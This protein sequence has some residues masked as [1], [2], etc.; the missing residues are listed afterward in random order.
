M[1]DNLRANL[2]QQSILAQG[3]TRIRR[4]LDLDTIFQ[5]TTAELLSVLGCD[6]AI[7]YQ[8]NPDWGGTIVAESVKPEWEPLRTRQVVEAELQRNTTEHENCILAWYKAGEPDADEPIEV[9]DTYLQENQGGIY[10]AGLPHRAVNDVTQAGFSDCYL[11]FLA[12]MQAKAYINTPLFLDGQLWGLVCV[13]QNAQPRVWQSEEINIVIQIGEHMTVALQQ[14]HLLKQTQQQA[15]NLLQAKETAEAANQAKSEFLSSMSHELR[16]PLNAIL[17]FAQLLTTATNLSPTQH[18]QLRIINRSG[19]HLLTL[20]NDVLEMSK[21]EAGQLAL[22]TTDCHLHGLL[23]DLEELLRLKAEAK[24]IE[25]TVQWGATVPS[26]TVIDGQKLRQVLI[27]LLGNAV[28]F[29]DVGVVSLLVQGQPSLAQQQVALTFRVQDTGCGIPPQSL[30]RIFEAFGQT[31]AGQQVEGTGLGL[32]IS[33]RFVQLMGGEI[34]VMSVE[35]QGSTFEF[36]IPVQVSQG[37]DL[38]G[39]QENLTVV[40]LEAEQPTYHLALLEGDAD[41]QLLLEQWLT[42]VGFAVTTCADVPAA[43]AHCQNQPTDLLLVHLSSLG[44]E[45]ATVLSTLRQ[46]RPNLKMIGITADAFAANRAAMLSEGIDRLLIKPF[47]QQTLLGAIATLIPVQYRYAT[48]TETTPLPDTASPDN[49]AF[50]PQAWQADLRQAVAICNEQQ[51]QDLLQELP[52]EYV[53]LR[54]KLMG[55]VEEFYFDRLIELLPPESA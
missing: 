53:S 20:I 7:I 2:A 21:I 6:R 46:D 49:L 29:T 54:Q 10:R 37:Q 4:S 11:E 23:Q 16:T 14:A 9:T 24:G 26:H 17:G 13:Y 52:A 1:T 22:N 31:R 12:R 34:T 19:E 5:T 55:W 43:I 28:K 30:Q 8:F 38:E 33:Q 48:P 40:G 35:N 25:L 41:S 42:T 51:I 15:I 44:P 47:N 32:T 50:M 39:I 27:N 18:N 3:I 45:A 36:T